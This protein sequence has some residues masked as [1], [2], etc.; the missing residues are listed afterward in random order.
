MQVD[1]RTIR[2]AAALAIREVEHHRPQRAEFAGAMSKIAAG[3]SLDQVVHALGH[4]DAIRRGEVVLT[5]PGRPD[6]VETRDWE[7][8]LSS[9]DVSEI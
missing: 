5:Y 3:M 6:A 9:P 8:G 1:S 2:E 7:P 4:P